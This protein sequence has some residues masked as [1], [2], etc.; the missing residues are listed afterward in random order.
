MGA[1]VRE[2]RRPVVLE[3]VRCLECGAVYGKPVAGGIVET[4]PG[5]PGC[6]YV[7]WAPTGADVESHPSRPPLRVLHGY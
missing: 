5:C 7:G 4:N 1:T 6:A 3:S 2:L